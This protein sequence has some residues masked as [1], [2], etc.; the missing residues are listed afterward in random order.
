MLTRRQ[1]LGLLATVPALSLIAKP[2]FAMTPEIYARNGVAVRGTDVV[3]YFTDGEPV[4]GSSEFTTSWKGAVWRFANAQNLAAF[5]ANPEA[6]APQYG[7]W[8]AWAVSRNYTAAT[9]PEAWTIYEGK[10]YL[11]A[12]LPTRRSWLRDV[13]GNVR[14]GDANWPAVLNK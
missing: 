1:T 2:A 10:L 5:E 6:Y 11:N 9:I 4:R 3:G 7:G 13:P 12:T 14:R 8:C